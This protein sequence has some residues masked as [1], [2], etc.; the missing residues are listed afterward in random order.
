MIDWPPTWR[1]SEELLEDSDA[2]GAR[3]LALELEARWPDSPK[4]CRWANVLAPP[5]LLGSRS[6]TLRDLRAEPNWLQRHAAE[7]PGCWIAVYG[8]HLV[9]ADP[10]LGAVTSAIRACPDIEDP[11]VVFQPRPGS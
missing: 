1:I 10:D 7:H 6:G 5:R 2:S 9:A 8:E 4:V 3:A 11:L